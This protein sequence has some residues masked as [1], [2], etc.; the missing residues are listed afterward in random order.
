MISYFY[1]LFYTHATSLTKFMIVFKFI[2]LLT[3]TVNTTINIQTGK[4]HR[5]TITASTSYVNDLFSNLNAHI[6]DMKTYNT[7]LT[8]KIWSVVR[9]T[10]CNMSKKLT[11]NLLIQKWE[12]QRKEKVKHSEVLSLVNSSDSY[13]HVTLVVSLHLNHIGQLWHCVCQK[14]QVNL[15]DYWVC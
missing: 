3:S 14:L 2:Y 11:W 6:P 12:R 4:W 15:W 5:T 13:W 9:S 10:R 7:S 1:H 8:I